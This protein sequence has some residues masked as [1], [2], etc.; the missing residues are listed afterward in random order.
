MSPLAALAFALAPAA[1]PAPRAVPPTYRATAPARRVPA[2][3][4]PA[5][6]DSAVA[7]LLRR[8]PDVRARPAAGG[9]VVTDPRFPMP[10]LIPPVGPGAWVDRAADVRDPMPN[11]WRP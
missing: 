2:Y 3:R 10:V 8:E 5:Y 9:F 11:A 4:D 1:E 7:R 6:R